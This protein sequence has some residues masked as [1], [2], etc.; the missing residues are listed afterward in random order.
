M[1]RNW[2]RWRSWRP[3]YRNLDSATRRVRI[4]NPFRLFHQTPSVGEGLLAETC[5]EIRALVT[6][7]PLFP[8]DKLYFILVCL[9]VTRGLASSSDRLVWIWGQGE[10]FVNRNWCHK[11]QL[12]TG[13]T[14]RRNCSWSYWRSSCGVEYFERYLDWIETMILRECR[15]M[16]RSMF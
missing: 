11:P 6:K 8:S 15:E 5:P 13:K 3:K 2:L 16:L 12:S 1:T 4:R 7:S 9:T 10:G 14:W